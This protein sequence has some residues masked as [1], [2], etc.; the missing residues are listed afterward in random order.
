M[1]NQ[2]YNRTAWN[3]FS[4]ILLSWTNLYGGRGQDQNHN[5]SRTIVLIHV[6]R[7]KL[8]TNKHGLFT[9][10]YCHYDFY[11]SAIT[12]LFN[13]TTCT[14]LNLYCSSTDTIYNYCK[15]T[16]LGVKDSFLMAQS[17]PAYEL[18]LMNGIKLNLF[19]GHSTLPLG[20][21]LHAAKYKSNYK[22]ETR[23]YFGK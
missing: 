21:E 16:L 3:E 10:V 6:Y 19:E 9:W 1:T 5:I 22:Y 7:R 2:L 15:I 4:V 8:T 13:G 17:I 14:V 11:F 23:V 18:L 12:I 20:P